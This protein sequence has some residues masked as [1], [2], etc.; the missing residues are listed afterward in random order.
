MSFA[1]FSEDPKLPNNLSVPQKGKVVKN[2]DPLKLGRLK[3]YIKGIYEDTSSDCAGI[4]WAFPKNPTGLGG[5]PDCSSF[6]VPEIDS[7]VTI[8]FPFNDINTPFYDGYWQSKL[9]TQSSLFSE[10]YPDSYGWVDSVIEFLRVNKKKPFVELF[11]RAFNDMVRWDEAG[12]LLIN[13]PASMMINIGT[14]LTVKIGNTMTT[15]AGVNST[16]YA[17]QDYNVGAGRSIGGSGGGGGIRIYTPDVVHCRSGV[18]VAFDAPQI[19][20]NSGHS[21]YHDSSS[22]DIATCNTNAQTIMDRVNQLI[23]EADALKQLVLQN[24]DKIAK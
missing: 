21:T 23:A 14:D 17:G 13:V 15:V 2:D 12:N 1:G 18:E 7:E 24:K 5:K 6:V 4:P 8:L 16:H 9:T 19:H 22:G 11:R 20:Q 3:C 10:D